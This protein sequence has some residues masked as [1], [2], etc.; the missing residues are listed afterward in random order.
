MSDAT[1]ASTE[2]AA[3]DQVT[4]DAGLRHGVFLTLVALLALALWSYWPVV[5]K[6]AK[7]WTSNDDYSVGMLV[8][9]AA[10]YMLW[11]QRKSL[12]KCRL[13]PFWGGLA[14]LA[15]AEYARWF[16]L[17]RL[18]ESAERYAF[19]LTV[20]ALVLTVAGL[21]F[22]RKT[23]WVWAFLFLMVPLPG[24]IHNAIADPLQSMATYGAVFTLELIG[25]TVERSGH[26]MVLNGDTPM[27]VAEA[28]SGLRMLTAF[29]VVSSLFAFVVH[30]PR[31][32]KA[33]VV[34]SSV[35]IAIA[36]NILRLVATALLF[37]WA[38]SGTAEKFFHDF[39]GLVMMPAAFAMLMGE[40]WILRWLEVAPEAEAPSH[41]VVVGG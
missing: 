34:I 2:S 20:F 14:V 13:A 32:H 15:L 6:L 10:L 16:G 41:P 33:T 39:A 3:T 18:F 9:P 36:C 4:A 12:R 22:T 35:P 1:I 23:F 38:S 19:V 21:Q 40:L 17:T 25:I 7:E 28:C 5:A 11:L 24:K 31:W 27:A 30:R 37:L 29:V 8:P 26:T